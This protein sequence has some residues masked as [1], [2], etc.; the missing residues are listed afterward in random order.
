M[1]RRTRPA[2]SCACTD[3]L[4]VPRPGCA[5]EAEGID[6]SIRQNDDC[7]SLSPA[8]LA[9]SD[10]QCYAGQ[11]DESGAHP[12]QRR[13]DLRVIAQTSDVVDVVDAIMN[14][15]DCTAALVC[16]LPCTVYDASQ[17]AARPSIM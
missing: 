8:R 15:L 10:G 1:A 5:C 3:R 13:S 17:Q 6:T 4:W 14:I 16:K 7:V 2:D 9:Q 11:R 12:H